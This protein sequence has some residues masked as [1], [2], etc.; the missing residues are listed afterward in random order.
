MNKNRKSNKTSET[1]IRTALFGYTV[2]KQLL[3]IKKTRF[4]SC[5]FVKTINKEVYQN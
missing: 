1:C 4:K 5:F 2:I 3:L